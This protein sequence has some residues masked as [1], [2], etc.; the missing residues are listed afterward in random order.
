MQYQYQFPFAKVQRRFQAEGVL[1]PDSSFTGERRKIWQSLWAKNPKEYQAVLEHEAR[2]IGKLTY[3]GVHIPGRV[4]LF[5]Q[6]TKEYY[7][8]SFCP[9]SWFGSAQTLQTIFEGKREIYSYEVKNKDGSVKK[10][11]AKR[12]QNSNSVYDNNTGRSLSSFTGVARSSK[13]EALVGIDL[14]R[15][16]VDVAK[17][18]GYF[19]QGCEH[20]AYFEFV[21]G[22]SPLEALKTDK[23]A[24]VWESDATLLA[25][26]ANAGYK[27]WAFYSKDFDDKVWDGEKLVLIDCEETEKVQEKGNA[28][29]LVPKNKRKRYFISTLM[30]CLGEYQQAGL[31]SRDEM[32]DYA[33]VFLRVRGDNSIKPKS[34]VSH[35]QPNRM[36]EERCFALCFDCD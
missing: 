1:T 25:R 18:L 33:R 35:I 36:T 21:H 16:G 14:L 5:P 27:H 12:A 20:Y 8:E 9:R 4:V 10:I 28:S 24:K 26:L 7:P 30:D 6:A 3:E 32:I 23:R 13:K 11:V 29:F 34:I 17:P 31:I 19:Y 15:K 2:T 22:Q